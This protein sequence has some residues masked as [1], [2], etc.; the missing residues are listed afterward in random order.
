MKK[1]TLFTVAVW[2]MTAAPFAS[3]GLID[4]GTITTDDVSGLDWLDLTETQGLSYDYVNSQ[5][6]AGG[7]WEGWR[8]ATLSEAGVLFQQFGFDLFNN[9]G[10]LAL[11][12]PPNFLAD[13]TAA[14]SYLGNVGDGI[15]VSAAAYGLLDQPGLDANHYRV[16]GAYTTPFASFAHHLGPTGGYAFG[17]E[18][19]GYIG[20]YLVRSSPL[21]VPEPGTLALFGLS[22]AGL[23]F[24]RRRRT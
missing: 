4:Q 9:S 7:L 10:S 23:G 11:H 20:S 21:S 19:Y 16:F 8:Y 15:T 5:L 12:A 18:T 13:L 2:L 22:L 6:G 3:A 24:A 17:N 14:T 1:I